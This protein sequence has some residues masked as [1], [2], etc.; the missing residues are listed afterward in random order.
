MEDTV[1]Q[2]LQEPFKSKWVKALRSGEFI[3]CT[4]GALTGFTPD[5]RKGTHCCLAVGAVVRGKD[6]NSMTETYDW[7]TS[8]VGKKEMMRLYEMNDGTSDMKSH[9]FPEIADYIEANL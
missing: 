4:T 1:K 9:S 2:K 3:Q 5:G 7:F 6:A 8:Q